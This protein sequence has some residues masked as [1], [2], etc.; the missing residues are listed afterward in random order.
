MP[1]KGIHLTEE[2]ALPYLVSAGFSRLTAN[3]MLCEVPPVTVL[4]ARPMY[5]YSLYE[6][7]AQIL[8]R[9]KSIPPVEPFL[10]RWQ[11]TTHCR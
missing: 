1:R 2:K 3:E 7:N 6:L 5:T 10:T 11:K 4:G 8:K 9:G